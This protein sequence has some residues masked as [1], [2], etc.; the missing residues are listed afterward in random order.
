MALLVLVGLPC[1]GAAA[2]K[3]DADATP[4]QKVIE[5]MEGMMAKGKEEKQAELVQFSEYKMFCENTKAA[6]ETAIS[7]ANEQIDL[8]KADIEK[9][10]A[11]AAALGE[12]VAALDSDIS[13]W[14][15][16]VKAATK[17][18]AIEKA[19]FDKMHL[20]Y[21]QSVD[22]LTMAIQVL[23]DQAYDRAQ[24]GAE[25][26]ANAAPAAFE[27]LS[28][29]RS[30]ELVPLK[31]KKAIEAFLQVGQDPDVGLSVSAPEAHGY[32]FRSSA[33]IATLEKLLDEFIAERTALEKAESDS[34]HAFSM[35]ESD[36]TH[37]IED[38][39]AER[40]EKAE[41]KAKKLQAKADAEGD[42]TDVTTTRDADV[43]YLDDL[44]ATCEQKA[45]DFESRQTLRNQELEAISKA[46][47]IISSG[48]VS[49]NADKY[50]PTLI[51]TKQQRGTALASLRSEVHKE[52]QERVAEY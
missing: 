5:L 22:A 52:T 21:S 4:V 32:D 39:T 19:D 18:R 49:G 10:T 46:I 24:A 13:V 31:A 48:A 9:Y 30:K 14:T 12:E 15:G 8:L 26:L 20:D 28:A 36:L 3:A 47:E 25:P 45:T 7:E 33:I 38:A 23:K 51:Q 50:L 37:Q 44:V 2:A 6:K 41:L 34:V 40:D 16:D 1:A 17:V 43:K 11:E 42:L 35:L 27:Q 29:L